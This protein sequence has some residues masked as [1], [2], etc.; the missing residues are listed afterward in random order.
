[1]PDFSGF[2][3]R[4]MPLDGIDNVVALDARV[5]VADGLSGS[6]V[7]T[8]ATRL[9]ASSLARDLRTTRRDFSRN[10]ITLLLG[11]DWLLE[12]IEIGVEGSAVEI[13]VSLD[14]NDLQQIRRLM[15]RLEKIRALV[16][17]SPVRQR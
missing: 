8:C 12:R 5:A 14:D 10:P 7:L 4:R 6:L 13:A 1:M 17:D 15:E 16:G 9:E 11:I 2:D 3:A